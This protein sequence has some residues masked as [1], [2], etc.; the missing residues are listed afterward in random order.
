[1]LTSGQ[2]GFL[3]CGGAN[4][5][6]G[7]VVVTPQAVTPSAAPFVGCSL[8]NA[9]VVVP[10]STDTPLPFSNTPTAGYF[11]YDTS[12]FFSSGTPTQV[13]IPQTGYY[14]VQGRVNYNQLSTGSGSVYVAATNITQGKY[15]DQ[16]EQLWAT[17]TGVSATQVTSVPYVNGIGYCFAGDVIKMICLQ[18][19]V[20]GA[21]YTIS[22][23]SC[24]FRCTLIP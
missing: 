24:T 13:V 22:A 12:G 21:S 7:L 2:T 15:F 23:G 6:S 18:F 16:T 11:I 19:Q 10:G 20:S 1:L 4:A 14:Q 3:V 17:N 9:S 8:T 5:T